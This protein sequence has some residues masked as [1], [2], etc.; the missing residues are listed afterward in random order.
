MLQGI[1]VG[2]TLPMLGSAALA[3]LAAGG[4]YAAASAVVSSTR[5]LGAVVG[6]A[7][8]VI[9]VGTPARGA[10]EEALRRGWVLAAVCFVA[11]AIGG[12]C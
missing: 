12:C 1:G 5:Q 3:G 4:S 6:I 11:V 2:A 7:L 9:V 8:L 10:A